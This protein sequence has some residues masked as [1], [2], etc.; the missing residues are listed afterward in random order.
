MVEAFDGRAPNVGV[1]EVPESDWATW[2]DLRLAALADAPYAFGETLA[3]AGE[4]TEAGWRSWW[5]DDSAGPRFIGA[6]DSVPRGMCAI[7]FPAGHDGEPLLISMWTSPEARG[8]GVGRAL[9]DACVAY[10]ERVGYARFRLSVVEDNLPARQ[11]YERYGFVETGGKEPLHSDPS[12]L[13]LWMT[14]QL[15]GDRA[16]SEL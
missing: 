14:L 8:C 13:V 11:L 7:C 10:C 1:R 15:S 12:K 2:R 9:L 6:V 5:S 3:K 4:Q 16:S